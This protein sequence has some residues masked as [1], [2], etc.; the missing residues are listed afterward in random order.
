MHFN[1]SILLSFILNIKK[2]SA[3]L[4]RT[5]TLI[6]CY[7]MKHYKL[8][9]REVIGWIRIC[10]PGSIIGPQQHW[11]DLKQPI[12]WQFGEIYR[13]NQRQLTTT[14]LA[15]SSMSSDEDFNVAETVKLQNTVKKNDLLTYRSSE[16]GLLVKNGR[17]CK[18]V[19][20]V[21]LVR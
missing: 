19:T 21:P 13:E 11:L 8:T 16:N 7:L 6:G 18:S 15:E 2:N 3:G 4:G 5:G 12:C 9:S 14:H 10:R 1:V 17:I 20:P